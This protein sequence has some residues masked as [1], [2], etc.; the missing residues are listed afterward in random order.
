MRSD[1]WLGYYLALAS[2]AI[3]GVAIFVNSLG[4]RMVA[5]ATLY[6]TLKNAVCGA[7]LLLPIVLLRRQR[8]EVLRLRPRDG[9]LLVVL[10]VIGGSIP[11]VL[12]FR[13]LQLT[14]AGT[15][16]LLNHA[17][18]LVV[19]LLAV[20][21]LRERL[22]G[23]A[24]LGL[25]LL[26]AGTL[27]GTD[28]AALRL[29]EGA[30]LVA[31][32]TL[33]FGGGMVLSRSLLGRLSPQLVMSAKMSAGAVVLA[34]YAAFTGHLA[35]LGALTLGRWG[36]VLATGL[37]LVA[38]TVT[39]TLAL[40]WAPAIAV[41][42]I[43]MASPPITIALQLASGSPLHLTQVGLLSGGLLVLGAA[44]FCLARG[45]ASPVAVAV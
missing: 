15:G 36:F 28:L 6:T 9:A 17:Q 23:F 11:Y 43:G 41:T 22:G 42:S 3:S 16:S 40:K 7:A 12:F 2:A 29:N 34:G 10:A 31:A 21:L 38:F 5:D 20:P 19:V 18:F 27:A 13:G 32:S 45:T 4:V 14:S 26:A 33:L 39:T 35:G 30:L 44:A 8:A 24:W 37:I 1:R 25:G